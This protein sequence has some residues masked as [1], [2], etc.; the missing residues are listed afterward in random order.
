[1][2]WPAASAHGQPSPRKHHASDSAQPR[3][4]VPSCSGP[5]PPIFRM[6]PHGLAYRNPR[7]YA[8]AG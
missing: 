7:W 5:R 3:R 8:E 1:M 2:C 6:S 4:P